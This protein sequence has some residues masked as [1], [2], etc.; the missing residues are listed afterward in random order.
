MWGIVFPVSEF[1]TS[2]FYIELG[3]YIISYISQFYVL[4]ILKLV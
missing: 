4:Y 3:V 1:S 2:Q